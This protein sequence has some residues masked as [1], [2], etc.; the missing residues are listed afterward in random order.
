[1]FS[2]I[3]LCASGPNHNKEVQN[4]LFIAAKKK[5]YFSQSDQN[6]KPKTSKK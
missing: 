2:T 5:V 4:L 6:S 3:I 1:M